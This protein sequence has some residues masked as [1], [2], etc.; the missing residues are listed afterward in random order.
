MRMHLR[1]HIEIN[2]P[3]TQVW[4]V[5]AHQFDAIGQWASSIHASYA[6]PEAPAPLGAE[7]GARVCAP[8]VRGFKDVR[9]QFTFYDEQAMRFAYEATA[10]LPWVVRRAENHWHVRPL[11]QSRCEVE[12]HAEVDL[13]AVP[14][15]FLAPLLKMQMHRLGRQVFE[16]LKYYVEHG[17]P[18][19]RKGERAGAARHALQSVSARR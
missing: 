15:V 17:Q 7:V 8:G 1:S 16:E 4:H 13:R 10:G 2:A 5:I 18:H 9:E 14:G 19:P 3:A 6:V 12:A 11:G